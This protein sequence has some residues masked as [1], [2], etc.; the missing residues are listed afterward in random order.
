MKKIVLSGVLLGILSSTLFGQSKIESDAF[1]NWIEESTHNRQLIGLGTNEGGVGVQYGVN[2]DFSFYGS[3]KT[4]F[5]TFLELSNNRIESAEGY[6][7]L[8][9]YGLKD[10]QV[11]PTLGLSVDT[12]SAKLG[13][14]AEIKGRYNFGDSYGAEVSYK[15]FIS[16]PTVGSGDTSETKGYIAAY[17][18]YQF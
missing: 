6:D 9:N 14:F 1:N 4:N 16:K 12:S 7:I 2:T 10:L 17:L 18:S 8:E 3:D 11:I 13:A 5:Y 15:Y